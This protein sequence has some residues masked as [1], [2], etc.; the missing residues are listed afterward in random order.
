MTSSRDIVSDKKA[1]ITL[2]TEK[3]NRRRYNKINRYYPETGKL[4]R[5]A[6]PKHMEFFANGNLYRERAI[7]AANRIGKT[8]GIGGY[9]LTLHLTGLYPD[10]WT[11]ERFKRFNH[12]TNC[13]A[14]GSTGQTVRDILQRKL[15]GP[16]SSFGTGLIPKEC[17][18]S[19]KRAP[20]TVPDKIERVLVYHHNYETD[21]VDGVSELTFKSYDQKRKAFEGTEQHVILLDEEPIMGIYAECVVRTMTTQGIILLTFTPLEGL[22]EVVLSFMPSGIVPDA[23]TLTPGTSKYIGQATWDDVPHLSKED[24]ASIL[25]AIPEYQRDARSKGIPQLGSGTIYSLSEEVLKVKDFALPKY[26]P[27]VYGLDVG[28]NWT[29]AVWGAIDRDNDVLYIYMTYKRGKA[30]PAIHKEAIQAKGAWIPGVIDPGANAASQFDGKRLL[31]AYRAMGLQLTSADNAVEAGIY[32]CWERM[33]TLRLKV[34][35]SQQGWFEEFRL[36]RRDNKGKIVKTNDHLMDAT[37]Y[38]ESSGLSLAKTEPLQVADIIPGSLGNTQS[39]M[40]R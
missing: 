17:I 12:P 19:T 18:A 3:M 7:M 8:E 35:E 36:Y 13:W 22:S 28:W 34:F 9:E 6:Y 11:G 32:K 14:C 37:R 30:E 21:E 15:L 20:G 39:W 4:K 27:R 29:A 33:S 38:L 5:D 2:L 16:T 26:W 31:T 23:N 25:A 10:W 40:D 24:K 1:Y